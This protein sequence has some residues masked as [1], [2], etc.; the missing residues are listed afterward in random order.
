MI[1][2]LLNKTCAS[3]FVRALFFFMAYFCQTIYHS[4]ITLITI[5][6]TCA[7]IVSA[8]HTPGMVYVNDFELL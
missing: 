8:G 2:S 4:G 1:T 3:L 7:Q 6:K 5:M